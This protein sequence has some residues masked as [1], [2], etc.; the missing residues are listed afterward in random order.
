MRLLVCD[1]D[2]VLFRGRN[3]WL[4]LHHKLGTEQYALELWEKFGRSDYRLLS[5]LTAKRWKGRDATPYHKL[6]SER[7]I[8]PGADR[9][10][11]YC[12]EQRLMTAIISSGPWH[13]ARRAQ[14]RWGID[15]IFANKLG[16]AKADSVFDGSVEVQ[17][18]DNSK[19]ST[20]AILQAELGV[21]PDETIV[22]GDSNA[23]ARMTN[24][25]NCSIGYNVDQDMLPNS[26]HFY[27]NDHLANVMPLVVSCSLRP[28]VAAAR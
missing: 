6:C 4:D 5:E 16:L 24:L 26:F 13:L 9:L 25:S 17:V 11:A 18:D 10:F 15:R 22:I 19:D 23:D 1:M 20:L 8:M 14:E 7:E 3:F 2:G 12:A 28:R 21:R 27:A